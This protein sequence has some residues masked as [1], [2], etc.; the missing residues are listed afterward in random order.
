MRFLMLLKAGKNS[1]AGVM[2]DDELLDAMGKYNEE[3]MKA[4]V[5]L[6]AEG[7]HPSAEGARVRFAGG[8]P[9]V[10]EG[11][12]DAKEL[13]AGLW[14]IQ[15]KSK[16]EAIEWAKR[17]PAPHG[18]GQAGEIELRQLFELEDFVPSE[19]I[20]RARELEKKLAKKK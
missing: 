13:I 15:V 12:F 2:P 16:E 3:M 9:R 20:A 4:G 1:E 14:M 17:A 6:G 19:A 5:L 8:K 7:L 11:P 18:E 10:I